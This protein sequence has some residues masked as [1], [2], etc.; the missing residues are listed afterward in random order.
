MK[1]GM[2]ILKNDMC[3]QGMYM[4]EGKSY[5]EEQPQCSSHNQFSN[6]ELPHYSDIPCLHILLTNINQALPITSNHIDSRLNSQ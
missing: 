4:P 3:V 1:I 6:A 2:N 5:W